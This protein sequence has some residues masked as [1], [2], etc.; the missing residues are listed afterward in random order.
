MLTHAKSLLKK[1]VRTAVL[2]FPIGFMLLAPYS[3]PETS[4]KR[5]CYWYRREK[6]YTDATYTTFCGM[7]TYFCEGTVG[8]SGC[9][10]LYATV[11]TCECGD[12]K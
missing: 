5:D 7:K 4:A 6:Y 11:E 12:Y 9:V 3:V 10:T 8:R 2:A 1:C